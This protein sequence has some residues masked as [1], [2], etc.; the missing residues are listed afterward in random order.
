MNCAKCAGPMKLNPDGDFFFCEFCGGFAL[1]DNAVAD[2]EIQILKESEEGS[3]VCSICYVPLALATL[4]GARFLYCQTCHGVLLPRQS[5]PQLI[6]SLTRKAVPTEYHPQPI[7]Q[8]ELERTIDCPHCT[9][10]M[11]VHPYYGPGNVVIDS[12]HQC[13]MIWL[14]HGEI[15]IVAQAKA[16]KGRRGQ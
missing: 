1:P 6:D 14:D 11:E 13:R 16:D 5:F 9:G 15:D 4:E 12:C 8:R 7:D 2:T 3:I 10:A